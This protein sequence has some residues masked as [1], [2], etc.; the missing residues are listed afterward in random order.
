MAQHIEIDGKK[1]AVTGHT[2]NG[3]PI[4]KGQ[5]TTV[6]HT[7]AQGRLMYDK[8]GHPVQSVHVSVSPIEPITEEG[9]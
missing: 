6:H 1:Y 9:I 4:I 5:S 2:A 3:T 8:D 7:D